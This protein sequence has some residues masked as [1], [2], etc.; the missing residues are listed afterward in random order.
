MVFIGDVGNGDAGGGDQSS[1]LR[2]GFFSVPLDFAFGGFFRLFNA[3][4]GRLSRGYGRIVETI[5]KFKSI[6]ILA[7][8]LLIGLTARLGYPAFAALRR[9]ATRRSRYL[10]RCLT[11]GWSIP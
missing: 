11:P 3:G 2:R 10:L 9:P 4:F 5:L 7:Y 8:I 6:A 1:L